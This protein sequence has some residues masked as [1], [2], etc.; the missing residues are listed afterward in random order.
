MQSKRNKLFTFFATEI[1]KEGGFKNENQE[2]NV[3]NILYVKYC[4]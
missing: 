1:K 4:P 3:R 2:N